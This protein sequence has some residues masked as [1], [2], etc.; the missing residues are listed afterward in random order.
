MYSRSLKLS[1]IHT[2][3]LVLNERGRR[4]V[5]HTVR[6]VSGSDW[7]RYTTILRTWSKAGPKGSCQIAFVESW[8]A[9]TGLH[10]MLMDGNGSISYGIGFR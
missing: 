9:T 8:S 1:L 2:G 7:T 6:H 10:I 3:R 4:G 5:D